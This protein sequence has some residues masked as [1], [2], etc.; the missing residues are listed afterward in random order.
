[1]TE[2]QEFRS[3]YDL[4]WYGGIV[5]PLM[6]ALYGVVKGVLVP[7]VNHAVIIEILKEKAVALA[8][9]RDEWR[10][11]SKALEQ[12]IDRLAEAVQRGRR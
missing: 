4:L 7:R 10:A 1:M 12:A 9:D 2:M 3:A 5:V 11:H 6:A 8:A